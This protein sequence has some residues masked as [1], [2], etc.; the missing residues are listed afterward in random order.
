MV[1]LSEAPGIRLVGL[2]EAFRYSDGWTLRGPPGYRM[3]ELLMGSWYSY[4]WTLRDPP[5]FLWMVS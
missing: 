3:V 5:V 4:G 1:G 2:S